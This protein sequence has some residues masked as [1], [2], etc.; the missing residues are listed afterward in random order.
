METGTD[1]IKGGASTNYLRRGIDSSWIMVPPGRSGFSGG[2]VSTEGQHPSQVRFTYQESAGFTSLSA[3]SQIMAEKL[4]STAEITSE[5]CDTQKTVPAF[6]INAPIAKMLR[7][8][9]PASTQSR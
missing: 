4:K 9:I 8:L 5:T 7:L 1:N 3:K 6:R 2:M